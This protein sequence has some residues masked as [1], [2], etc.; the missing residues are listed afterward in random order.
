MSFATPWALAG[1]L[2]LV[3]LVLLHLR[4]RREQLRDVPSL[5]LWHEFELETASGQR[6]LRRPPLPLIL[7]LQAV[8]LVLLVLAL[9]QPSLSSGREPQTTV[10]VVDGSHYMQLPG[11]LAT[12]EQA[13]SQAIPHD[14]AVRV[15]VAGT[16][17]R[18]VY[19]GGAA[20]AA[21]ALSDIQGVNTSNPDLGAALQTA[22]G[23]LTGP[24]DRILLV[25]APEDPAPP[26]TARPGQLRDLIVGTRVADLVI[27]SASAGCGLSDTAS[28]EVTAQI[29]NTGN[30]A[31]KARVRAQTS[32]KS[33]L[34]LSAT[35]PAQGSAVVAFLSHSGQRVKLRLLD[36]GA[37]SDNDSR[38]VTVPG[39]QDIPRSSTV[40]LV[41][42]PAQALPLA[43]AFA[44]VP[45]V[46]LRLRTPDNYRAAD[47][48]GA[49]LVVFDGWLPKHLPTAV[50]A[51]MLV[52]APRIPGGHVGKPQ[53]DTTV[54]GSDTSSPLLQGGVDLS[55]LSISSGGASKTALP[56]WLTPVVWSPSG[57]LLAAGDNGR[58]RLIVMPFHPEESN[59]AQLQAL[60]LL[61]VNVVRWGLGYQAAGSVAS[62]PPTP[63]NLRLAGLHS[64]SGTPY[65]LT[66]WL[67]AGALA[68]LLIEAFCWYRAPA[69]RPQLTVRGL[70]TPG[71]LLGAASLVFLAVAL[72]GPDLHVGS[73][74]TTVI[75]A[76]GS[77]SVGARAQAIERRVIKHTRSQ[78][79][80]SPCTP[81][82]FGTAQQT[83][84]QQALSGAL[85]LAPNGGQLAVL[86]DGGQTNGNVLAT[87]KL[88]R[89]RGV[90]IDWVQLPGRA[91]D[92]A[93]TAISAPATVRIGDTIPLSLTIRATARTAVTLS[94]SHDGGKA[95]SQRIAV[96]RG[97]NPLL[98]L[99]NAGSRGWHTFQA[100]V[101][102]PGDIVLSNDTAATTVRVGSAPRV[103]VVSSSGSSPAAGILADQHLAVTTA[104]A[105][106]LPTSVAGYSRYATVVLDDVPATAMSSAQVAALTTAVRQGGAGLLVLG[107]NHSFSLGR[108]WQSPLQQILP[109]TSLVPGK[110]QRRNLALELVL[111][112]SGSM[113]DE[114]GGVPKIVL[115]RSAS[116]QTAQFLSKHRDSLGI[117]DFDITPHLLLPLQSVA[118]GASLKRVNK[119]IDS[120][121]ADG[122]TNIFLGL[123]KGYEEIIKSH[124]KN[125]H[126]ILMTDGISPGGAYGPLL[127]K[128]RKAHI[129][130]A[131]VA[132]GEDADRTL[133]KSISEVTGGHAYATNNARDLPRILVKETQLAAKPVRVS[134]HLKASV[135]G[136]SPI[137]RSLSGK[138]LPGLAG[139]VVVKLKSG[140][141]ADLSATGQHGQTDPALAQWQVGA[142][143]VA[144]WTPGLS[145]SWGAGWQGEGP[146]WNDAV[147]WVQRG[148]A[149]TPL[150]PAP[151]PG[152]S[153][154]LQVDLSSLG[155]TASAV[156]SV[157]GTLT[158][159][160]G[161][162]R[163]V[164]FTV[165][166]PGLLRA[167]VGQLTPGVYHFDLAAFGVP[168]SGTGQ[169]STSSTGL[170]P[171]GLSAAGEVAI[172]Y[173]TE[174]S[175]ITAQTSQLG[176]LAAQTGGQVVSPGNVSALD[177]DR[178]DLR[179]LLLMLALATFLLGVVARLAPDVLRL[180]AL[181]PGPRARRR[182]PVPAAA[183]TDRRP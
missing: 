181:R 102:A 91:P 133:L 128:F 156:R 37:L 139:N 145:S 24:H 183:P 138:A 100:Q 65:A 148:L 16:V 147:R 99:Y 127:Q 60:P 141:Q 134:G 135:N 19:R 110:L 125:R 162:V 106:S 85:A 67:V 116:R 23:L 55:S 64:E 137:V 161:Q 126:V 81:V 130:V 82:R 131:T 45:G 58:Q 52:A 34:T 164:D 15:V 167:D 26:V 12:A 74:R 66:P 171:I 107:G 109:V 151:T 149:S 140:A 105:A 42:T 158:A 21:K 86:S 6:R 57:T 153:G 90:R 62:G 144:V 44:A 166:A 114:A 101:S 173:S 30:T 13:V 68:L 108:Y 9:S 142:G 92:A 76:D 165:T 98:L 33:A 7:L 43:R 63:V 18:V 10:V 132:L 122:G 117:V 28:C 174:D 179:P 59:L 79:C 87:A 38:S 54:S 121:Q 143:R 84:L 95:T 5:L 93:I 17:P 56:R 94:I 61:A 111:D 175:P 31:V 49:D 78:R 72:A 39:A 118:P 115:T 47:T 22:A 123:K 170:D 2:L 11:R 27:S 80:A 97:D 152:A 83:D 29:R 182:E 75:A 20:G 112:H 53:P 168:S 69:R 8:A 50:P 160:D 155:V 88:A 35:V 169:E 77:G 124:A 129:S 48:H 4:N 104:A 178:Y 119:L 3:P 41:G 177:G 1:L 36:G 159:P 154:S 89:S 40:T 163:R 70:L 103:L 113:L 172:P 176:Q 73:S 25:R 32:A 46:S 136:D 120:L 150:L 96:Q 71:V 180:E 14:D 157:S 51:E 146:L